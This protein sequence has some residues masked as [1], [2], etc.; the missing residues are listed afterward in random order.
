MTDTSQAAFVVDEGAAQAVAHSQPTTD[1]AGAE[2]PRAVQEQ[3]ARQ[4]A[5]QQA[6]AT[7]GHPQQAVISQ[8]MINQLR[9][10]ISQQHYTEL[11][12]L[13]SQLAEI[14]QREEQEAAAAQAEQE[15]L[16]AERK[17]A[18][19]AGMGA[20]AF[21]EAKTAELQAEIQKIKDE[22]ERSRILLERERE[23]SANQELRAR[24]LGSEEGQQIIPQFRDLVQGNTPEELQASLQD[25]I[26]RS[27]A[28]V[29]DIQQQQAAWRQQAPG[30]STRAPGA[31]TSP[32]EMADTQRQMSLDELKNLSNAD[33]ARLRPQLLNVKPQGW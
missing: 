30:V 10:E 21:A 20:K 15:R 16:E 1:F 27:N 7:A 19:E 12:E 24:L 31:L 29:Q 6:A 8:E 25:M 17:A 18:E 23:F 32:T 22:A 2:A 11:S 33:Y 13:K 4:A 3:A 9:Q 14:R 26:A 5:M 28:V